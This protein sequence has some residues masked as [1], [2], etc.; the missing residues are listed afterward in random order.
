MNAKQIKKY[1]GMNY[2]EKFYKYHNL[3]ICDVL[4]CI[5]CSAAAVNLH[6][7]EYGNGIKND[8]PTN[9]VPMCYLHHVWHHTKNNPTTEEIKAKQLLTYLPF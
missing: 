8:D 3:D 6:H 4:P 7:I 1:K 2:K 9:L 5:I